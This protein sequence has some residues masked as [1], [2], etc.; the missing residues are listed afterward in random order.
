MMRTPA[1]YNAEAFP[2]AEQQ[3]A[4]VKDNNDPQGMGRVRV[5]FFWQKGDELSRG[6]E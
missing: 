1:D 6:S 4:I 5:Q 2:K 3:P